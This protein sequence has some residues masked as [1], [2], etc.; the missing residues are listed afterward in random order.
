MHVAVCSLNPVHRNF[1]VVVAAYVK[2]SCVFLGVNPVRH[3]RV[4]LNHIDGGQWQA[5]AVRYTLKSTRR[6]MFETTQHG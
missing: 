4:V 2:R 3:F 1:G 5:S 6:Q